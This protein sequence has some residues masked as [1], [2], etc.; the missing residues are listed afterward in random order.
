MHASIIVTYIA[1]GN[2]INDVT[3]VLDAS[4]QTAIVIAS[5]VYSDA[6]NAYND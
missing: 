5:Y 4:C 3:E 6:M 1:T 2:N